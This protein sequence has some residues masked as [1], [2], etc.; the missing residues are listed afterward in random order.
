MNNA[1]KHEEC[2]KN[3]NNAKT[4]EQCQKWHTFEE[5][6]TYQRQIDQKRSYLRVRKNAFSLIKGKE[7]Y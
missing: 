7:K 3:M 2:Q 6:H 5:C 1:K 4:H